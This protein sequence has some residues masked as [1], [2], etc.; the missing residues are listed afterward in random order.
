MK[1]DKEK[2]EL[3]GPVKSVQVKSI[4]YQVQEDGQTIEMPGYSPTMIF[5]RD[6]WIIEQIY[7]NPDGSKWRVV[8]DYSETGKLITTK[9][10]N[11]S[12]VPVSEVKYIYDD[13]GRLT[14]EQ[15]QDQDGKITTP[16][17]YIYDNEGR[18][19]KIQDLSFIE[20]AGVI[21]GIESARTGIGYSGRMSRS[22][23]LYNDKGEEIELRVF[24]IDGVLIGRIEITRDD[25]GNLLE[26]RHYHGDVVEFSKPAPDSKTAKEMAALTEEKKAEIEEETAR[27]FSPGSLM[28]KDIYKYNEAGMLIERRQT[29]M[30]METGRQTFNYDKFG[31]KSEEINYSGYDSSGNKVIYTRIYIRNYDSNGNWT[32]EI[33][34]TTSNSNGSPGITTLASE[35]R[36]TII[37]YE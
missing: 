13:K 2:Q 11:N 20:D 35:T 14:A 6:G 34:E 18:K 24:N 26:V 22:E 1:T 37:Y 29:M 8:N 30:G 31:N 4:F 28:S 3:K 33:V 5:N 17:T 27:M 12:D 16:T 36:R 9:S 15:F 25:S 7:P 23:S 32:K 21:V 10:Y 19:S